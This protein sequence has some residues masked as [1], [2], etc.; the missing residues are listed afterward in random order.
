MPLVW[1]VPDYLPV[2]GRDWTG[3]VQIFWNYV[4]I[5]ICTAFSKNE[6]NILLYSTFYCVAYEKAM[7]VIYK[8]TIVQHK[9]SA[10]V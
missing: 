3:F 6:I 8:G 4:Q 5:Q 7:T 1:P 9:L 10:S 2:P